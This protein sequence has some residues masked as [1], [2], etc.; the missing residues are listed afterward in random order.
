MKRTT[1]I[2]AVALIAILGSSVAGFAAGDRDGDKSKR[3]GKGGHHER[4]AGKMDRRGPMMPD[5]ATLDADGDGK[6]TEAEIA[7]HKA[8]Q[9]AEV[10]TDG[11]GTVSAEELAA[12]LEAKAEKRK[13]DRMAKM[14]ERM[15]ADGDGE[16]SADEMAGTVKKTP[17]ERLDTDGDGALSEEEMK[18]GG[19][20]GRG[21]R[22]DK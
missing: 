2:S 14:I 18:A 8:A 12:H 22:G 6:V 5:F 17:F 15:D 16:L 10:D 7:A 4:M 9:F 19:E 20:R 11:N 13:A 21:G 1:A 3:M